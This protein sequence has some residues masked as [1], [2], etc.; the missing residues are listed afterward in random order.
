[1]RTLSQTYRPNDGFWPKAEVRQSMSALASCVKLYCFV[2]NF[3][4]L[5]PTLL[6]VHSR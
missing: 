4:V 6:F 1:M 5:C 2:S 3:I